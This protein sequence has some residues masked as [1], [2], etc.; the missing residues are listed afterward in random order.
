MDERA[1]E[2]RKLR[3]T[4]VKDLMDSHKYQ[5]SE[6]TGEYEI[7]P[8]HTTRQIEH[9]SGPEKDKEISRL[10]KEAKEYSKRRKSYDAYVPKD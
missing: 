4:L 1:R 6:V 7:K 2:R 5:K 8:E 3:R 10:K 9:L